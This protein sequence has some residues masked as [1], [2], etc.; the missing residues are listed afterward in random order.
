MK[1]E[2]KLFC[3]GAVAIVALVRASIGLAA[4]VDLG[5][6]ALVLGRRWLFQP[7]ELKNSGKGIT[8][9]H[10]TMELENAPPWA[11]VLRSIVN[12]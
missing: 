3:Q 5:E 11:L 6:R 1:S 9:T 2:P 7:R 4:D 8:P 10:S 12:S